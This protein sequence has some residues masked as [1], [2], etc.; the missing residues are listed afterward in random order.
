METFRIRAVPGDGFSTVILSG[1]ADLAVAPDLVELGTVC[2]EE[3]NCSSLI[4]DLAAV[5]FID[6]T[7][8]GAMIRLHNLAEAT[9]KTVALVH[10]PNRVQQVLT[11]AGLG[12][13]LGLAGAAAPGR[14]D[15]A[16]APTAPGTPLTPTAPVTT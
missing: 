9:G 12:E 1:E 3:A 4:I 6:S 15:S 11:L 10:V 13:F 14:T 16:A 7:A 2:L 5:T 8:I